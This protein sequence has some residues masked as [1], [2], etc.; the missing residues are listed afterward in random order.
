MRMNLSKPGRTLIRRARQGAF[1]AAAAALVLGTP[2]VAA[3]QGAIAGRVTD[4]STLEPL[5]GAQVFIQGTNLGELTDQDGRYRVESVPA[6]TYEVTVRLIGYRQASRSDVAV[7]SGQ[8]T[9]ANFAID[10]AAVAL[11]E[12][13]TTITGEQRRRE[14]GYS[15]ANI[16]AEQVV[17]DARPA[18]VTDLIKGRATGVTVRRSSGSVGTGS[19]IKIRGTASISQDVTPLIVVDGAFVSNDNNANN[20][21]GLGGQDPSRLNDINPEDIADIEIIKGPAAAALY[22]SRAAA[23]IIKITTKKGRTGVTR[24]TVRTEVGMESNAGEFNA[25]VFN[26]QSLLGPNAT[27][28]LYTLNLLEG[29]A[30]YDAPFRAGLQQTYGASVR[31]GSSSFSYFASGQYQNLEGNLP[32][33]EREGVNVRA[34]FNVQP[35]DKV[36]ISVSNGFLTNSTFFPQNDNNAAGYIGV[37]MIAFPWTKMINVADPVTGDPVETCPLNYEFA[38]LQGITVAQADGALGGCPDNPFFSGRTFEDIGTQIDEQEI[39]RYT[40]SATL[41]WRPLDNWTNRAT[42][43]YDQFADLVIQIVPVDPDRPF[44]AASDGAIA[45]NQATN[46]NLTLE[47]T[48]SLSLDLNDD[49]NFETTVG[50]QFFRTHIEGVQ[51]TGNVFPAGGP[52]VGNSVTTTA[53]DFTIETRTIGVFAQE[54]IGWK[55][56]LFITPAVRMDDNSAAGENL[57]VQWYPRFAVAYSLSEE[58]FAPDFFESLKLRASFGQ[59]GQQPGSNDALELL[60]PTR[61]AIGNSDLVGVT[62]AQLGN[63]VLEPARSTEW[64]AGF[65]ASVLRGRLGVEFTYFNSKTANDVVFRQVAPSTG[66]PGGQFVNVGEIKNTGLELGLDATAF[67]NRDIT[68]GWRATLSH[69][70]NEV[71]RL[72]DPII[73]GLGGASQRHTE[74]FPFASYFAEEVIIDPET[75][76]PRVLTCDEDASRGCNP[77]DNHRFLGQPNPTWEGSLSTTVNLFDHITVYGLVDFQTGQELFNSTDEFR[78]GFLGGGDPV[79]SGAGTCS[80]MFE[81]DSDGSYTDAALIAQEASRIGSEAPWIEDADFA[82]LRTVSVRFQLPEGWTTKLR[83]QNASIT[84]VG[85]NLVTWT[86]YDGLDPEINFGGQG[87]ATRA[88]FL[89]LP[90]SRRF[91]ASVSFTF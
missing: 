23:G 60:N 51:T 59:A 48:S 12:I 70:D 11:D 14:I 3:Q 66:N 31:G 2:G 72:D 25:S 29:D 90:P 24:W 6:G 69:I 45:N 88:D 32:D 8:V 85:E 62:P 17:A 89:T 26:P 67:S 65:D 74:G 1:L 27:D 30:G 77:D 53:T 86:G 76:D 64:E 9:T 75:G 42:I 35:S 21:I 43:G 56:K 80:E 63:A 18:S 79:A 36:D 73:F 37:A 15:T 7:T 5:V 81:K 33:N 28:T 83:L 22:G 61:V 68:W 40:G 78:C 39:E 91:L 20:G 38:R 10:V 87:A 54:Q 52:T 41:N 47:G 13:V 50:G 58:E 4:A 55:D 34:N 49:W 16:A 82:K 57:G 71:T 46:R 84:L 19:E 44:G